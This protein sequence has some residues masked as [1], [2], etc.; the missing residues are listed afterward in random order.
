[1]IIRQISFPHVLPNSR[2]DALLIHEPSEEKNGVY[3][4]LLLIYQRV[5]KD[6]PMLD[7][8]KGHCLMINKGLQ[9]NVH[10]TCAWA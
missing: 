7:H 2:Y 10:Q 6:L 1:M 9:L 4:S 3:G 5:C 8:T